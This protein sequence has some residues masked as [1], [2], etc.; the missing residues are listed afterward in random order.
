M[1]VAWIS[2]VALALAACSTPAEKPRHE[3]KA[4]PSGTMAK[5]EKK[6]KVEKVV[7]KNK[8]MPASKIS[9][10]SATTLA[11]A[12]E[13]ALKKVP[14]GEAL[15]AEIEIENGKPLIEVKIFSHGKLYEVEVDAT[16]GAVLEVEQEDDD[17]DDDDEDED[18]GDEDDD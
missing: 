7:K 17:D 13:S 9:G 18:D 2:A 15:A 10:V 6:V 3:Q 16:T 4:A 14:G 12:I 11:A 8:A 5:G 1:K